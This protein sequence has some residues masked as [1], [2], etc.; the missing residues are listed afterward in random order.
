MSAYFLSFCQT[1]KHFALKIFKSTST[2]DY[3]EH[4]LMVRSV[5]FAITEFYYPIGLVTSLK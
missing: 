3:N 4:L 1:V 5:M 2:H